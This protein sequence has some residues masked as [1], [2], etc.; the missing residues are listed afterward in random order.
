[1]IGPLYSLKDPFFLGVIGDLRKVCQTPFDL[2][3]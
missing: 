1:M 3:F 2:L